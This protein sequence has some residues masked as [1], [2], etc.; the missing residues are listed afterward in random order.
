[1]RVRPPDPGQRGPRTTTASNNEVVAAGKY[2]ATDALGGFD[3]SLGV[4]PIDPLRN[5]VVQSHPWVPGVGFADS[6]FATTDPVH[7]QGYVD[8]LRPTNP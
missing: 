7:G 8:R 1:M 2:V 4:L 6:L 5:S 3:V